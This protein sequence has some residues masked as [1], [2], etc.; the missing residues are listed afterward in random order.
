ME[1][2]S[3]NLSGAFGSTVI[4][5]IFIVKGSEELIDGNLTDAVICIDN[6]INAVK[7]SAPK[8]HEQGEGF[9]IHVHCFT[10]VWHY[11]VMQI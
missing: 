4:G 3:P 8:Q 6:G 7:Q 10:I 5:V 2:V 1:N 11:F 9:I